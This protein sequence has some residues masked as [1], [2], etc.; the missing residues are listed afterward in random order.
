M[1]LI[2]SKR[3]R[4][5]DEPLKLPRVNLE[6]QDPE[7]VYTES[8]AKPAPAPV[9]A[10][11]PA[12][13][14][15]L[16]T[17]TKPDAPVEAA[18]PADVEAN[19]PATRQLEPLHSDYELDTAELSDRNKPNEQNPYLKKKNSK[20]KSGAIAALVQGGEAARAAIASGNRNPLAI[21]LGGALGG[22]GAGA[23]HDSWD[24]E[25]KNAQRKAEL[26]RNIAYTLGQSEKEADIG[27]KAARP[28]LELKKIQADRDIAAARVQIQR[29]L[30]AGRMT[31]A[32]ADLKMRQLDRQ[33][34][35][36]EGALNRASREK[37][38]STKDLKVPDTYYRGKD[39]DRLKDMAMERVLSSGQYDQSQIRPEVL[40]AFGGDV[41]KLSKAIKAGTVRIDDAF[42][43][44][45]KGAQF[46]KDLAGAHRTISG[47]AQEFDRAIDMTSKSPNATRI[48]YSDFETTWEKFLGDYK[49]AKDDKTRQKIRRQYEQALAGV[50]LAGE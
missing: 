48:S 4:N 46:Q 39:S 15:P 31:R 41:E 34:R 16:L 17:F 8:E 23:A 26:E 38:A 13:A 7:R 37:V 40:Q 30:E 44:P 12:G 49:A 47:E 5:P 2:L 22:F 25:E 43:D 21:A 28:A 35:E 33:S 11:A 3:P 32:E 20:L 19:K 36:R 1:G 24:E 42:K 10:A 27:Y 29:D 9:A 14:R 18:A 6:N 45:T 50:R